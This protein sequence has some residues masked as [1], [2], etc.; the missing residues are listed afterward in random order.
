M[1][2]TV[3]RASARL[4]LLALACVGG[5]S[6]RGA[7]ATPAR[8]DVIF[9]LDASGSMYARLDGKEKIAIAK[10][11]L[12]NLVRDL[13]DDLALGLQVYG[14]RRKGDCNDIEMLVP[15]GAARK[16]AVIK[17]VQALNPK[18][19][20]PL[21]A[22]VAAAGEAIKASERDATVVLVSDGKETCAGDPC[23]TIKSLRE[24]GIN[25]RLHVVGFAVA[26]DEKQQLTCMADAGGGRYFEAKDASELAQALAEVKTVVVEENTPALPPLSRAEM[27]T[28]VASTDPLAPTPIAAGEIVKGRLADIAKGGKRHYW[29]VATPPGRYK[30]V[31]DVRRADEK[32]SNVQAEVSVLAPDGRKSGKAIAINEVEERYRAVGEI[33]AELRPDLVLQVENRE[34]IVDYWMAL[35]APG[36][37]VP[38]PFFTAAP[39][40]LPFAPGAPVSALLD[41]ESAARGAAYYVTDLDGTD[42][43]LR[44]G[45]ARTDNKR[46]NVA[47][48][49]DVFDALG[50][51]LL[52][53]ACR[54]NQVDVAA[55]CVAKISLAEPAKV[56]FR[57]RGIHAAY[58]ATLSLQP[59]TQ[60]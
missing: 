26:E 56:M 32:R 11:V 55:G 2:A 15:A 13:P 23:A 39:P 57:V 16:E 10:D 37:T 40:V 28:K 60:E 31:L 22:S 48:D 41:P 46:S 18:G 4:L 45:L 12:V 50:A 42:Y 24:Q 8:G 58:R 5:W 59:W 17:A 1:R 35:Y 19:E 49:V 29:K 43:R 53:S 21:A 52:R 7:A 6:G 47:G 54:I 27:S 44:F 33:D 9:I 36:T 14:H 51:R 30:L 34:S 3:S 25:M 38:V 20:T